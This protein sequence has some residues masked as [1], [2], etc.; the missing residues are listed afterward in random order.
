[1]KRSQLLML[2]AVFLVVII[3]V[4]AAKDMSNKQA[5]APSADKAAF[6][7]AAAAAENTPLD[8]GKG[9]AA[10]FFFVARSSSLPDINGLGLSDAKE[11]GP[12]LDIFAPASQYLAE[13]IDIPESTIIDPNRPLVALTFDDGP[14][15]YTL[16]ILEL[17]N[18]YGARATF[19]IVGNR[20]E[21]REDII[22]AIYDQGSEIGN[23]SWDHAKL[24]KMKEDAVCDNLQ[25]T[26][27]AVELITGCAPTL[28]RPPYGGIDADII[29]ACID[30]DMPIITWSIDTRDW[31]D[32]D[33]QKVYD[34]V[35]EQVTDGSIILMHDL[36][37]STAE[38]M[39]TVI[40]ALIEQGYQL[41]TVSELLEHYNGA[42]L[43]GNIYRSACP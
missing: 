7:M 36:Y 42:K 3:I 8:T 29:N 38:A 12:K 4:I 32:R 33:A 15:P 34:A 24:V 20:I 22:R 17:L 10:A 31:K 27:D 41:V 9:S 43:P 28:M 39:K 14:A 23:H 13:C 18:T 5:S 37:E 25:K 26:N 2:L 1:M 35:M 6:D 11:Q 19:F 30:L 40:P 16:P 21:Y